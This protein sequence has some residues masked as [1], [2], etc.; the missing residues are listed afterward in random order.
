MIIVDRVARWAGTKT[1]PL[2]FELVFSE[3]R[4]ILA[5]YQINSAIGDQFCCDAISQHL[6]KLGIFY[7]VS[8]FAAHTRPTIFGNLKH[9]LVQQKI[10]LLDDQILLRQLRSLREEKTER[11]QIDVRPI[12]GA[13]DDLA[14]AVALAARELTKQEPASPSI[15]LGIVQTFSTR[16]PQLIPG[17]C[18]FEA[19]CRN[20]PRCL[21]AGACQGFDRE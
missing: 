16:S 6:L 13:R 19:I 2:A 11:G 15:Q 8:V 5:E 7:Q 18:P 10:E 4:D 14:V 3:V 9:L 1:A 12:G 17:I 21:D 20:F